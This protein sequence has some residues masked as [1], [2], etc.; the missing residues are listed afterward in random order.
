[1]KNNEHEVCIQSIKEKICR[2]IELPAAPSNREIH[3]IH[4]ANG[5]FRHYYLDDKG[6]RVFIS[7]GQPEFTAEELSVLLRTFLCNKAL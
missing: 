4:S 5:G 6:N 7:P 2:S 3:C 1:M